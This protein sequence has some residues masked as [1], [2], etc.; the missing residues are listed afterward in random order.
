MKNISFIIISPLLGYREGN[1]KFLKMDM[2]KTNIQKIH[3]SFVN[4]DIVVV[5]GMYNNFYK[6]RDGKYRICENQ[7]YENSGEI[8]QIRLG[9]NNILNNKIVILKEDCIFDPETIKMG[10]KK[11]KEFLVY[12]KRES[13]P[14][15]IINKDYVYNISFG[16]DNPFGDIFFLENSLEEVENFIEKPHNINKKF[17]ELVNHLINI[18]P[19]K[20]YKNENN[21]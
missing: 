6:K 9:L 18:E 1:K 20:I 3:N 2:F 16:L 21:N 8:E 19:I 12:G 11:K 4:P 7:L 10:I 5:T 17:Y 13:N 15:M 14:G